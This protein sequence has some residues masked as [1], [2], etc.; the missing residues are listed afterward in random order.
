ML[1]KYKFAT[2]GHLGVSMN[3]G[4][5]IFLLTVVSAIAAF[6]TQATVGLSGIS[7]I[8]RDAT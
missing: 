8:V 3:K 6:S 4:L 2:V 5:A 7:G 1:P